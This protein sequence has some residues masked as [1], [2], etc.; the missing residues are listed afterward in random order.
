ML[1]PCD[2]C[3]VLVHNNADV[4]TECAD[5]TCSQCLSSCGRGTQ[6]PLLAPSSTHR[7]HRA[8]KRPME[9][10]IRSLLAHVTS[11][12]GCPGAAEGSAGMM[13]VWG[14]CRKHHDCKVVTSAC[15]RR[16]GSM[17]AHHDL[18]NVAA[19]HDSHNTKLTRMV[20]GSCRITMK[21]LVACFVVFF[22][23]SA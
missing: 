9:M 2:A 19:H 8:Y 17:A 21:A 14:I 7:L 11:F 4:V 6:K 1:Q 15:A 23:P 22:S 13:Y 5:L 3:K 20:H 18:H 12:S 16:A 10:W